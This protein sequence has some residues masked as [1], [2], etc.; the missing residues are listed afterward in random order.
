[1][2]LIKVSIFR[3]ITFKRPSADKRTGLIDDKTLLYRFSPKKR[4]SLSVIVLTYSGT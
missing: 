1:M 3:V 4:S 2:H